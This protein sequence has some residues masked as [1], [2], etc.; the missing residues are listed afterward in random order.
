MVK[1]FDPHDSHDLIIHWRL[2]FSNVGKVWKQVAQNSNKL[3]ITW[4]LKPRPIV[5]LT[6][7]ASWL[8]FVHL[9]PYVTGRCHYIQCLCLGGAAWGWIEF[10]L[11]FLL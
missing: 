4:S 6:F 11:L 5:K 8:L 3:N 10:L 2:Y 9:V 1:S 7:T